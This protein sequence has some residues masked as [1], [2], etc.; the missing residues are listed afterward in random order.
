M[1]LHLATKH[2]LCHCVQNLTSDKHDWAPFDHNKDSAMN[3]V[4]VLMLHSLCHGHESHS[5]LH[6]LS[7]LHAAD[8][9]DRILLG[10]QSTGD[11]VPIAH[12]LT[13]VNTVGTG[14]SKIGDR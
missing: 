12:P 11:E 4:L 5:V 9:I 8:D 3:M 7:C 10:L 2:A 14:G 1:T 6:I 13:V